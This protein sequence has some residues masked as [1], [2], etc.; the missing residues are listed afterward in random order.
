MGARKTKSGQPKAPGHRDRY[1]QSVVN[2]FDELN[3]EANG[4]EEEDKNEAPEEE[5]KNETPD[6]TSSL[7]K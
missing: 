4:G 6:V 1:G 3:D 5:D 7:D 2:F